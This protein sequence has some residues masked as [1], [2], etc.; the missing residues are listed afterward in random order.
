MPAT[1]TLVF[2]FPMPENIANRRGH[3][4]ANYRAGKALAATCDMLQFGAVLPPPPPTPW[5]KATVTARLTLY[6]PMDDDN[7]VARCKPLLDWLVTR[8]YLVDDR[9]KCLRWGAMPEQRISRK[10]EP[11][12]EIVLTHDP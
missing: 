11:E 7:A 12:I 4:S 9:R 2:R 1:E 10:N 3:W 6:N 5:A 8:G